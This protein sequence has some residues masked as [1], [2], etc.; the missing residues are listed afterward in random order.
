MLLPSSLF[1]PPLLESCPDIRPN[2]EFKPEEI[3]N[4]G[5]TR[6]LLIRSWEPKPY[7]KIIG[8]ENMP[9]NLVLR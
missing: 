8:M 9:F 1:L 4:P 7:L 2:L 3:D 6:T 5:D